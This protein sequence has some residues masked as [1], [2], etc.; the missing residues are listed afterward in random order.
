VST[1]KQLQ[2]PKEECKGKAVMGREIEVLFVGSTSVSCIERD[3]QLL[4]KYF[5]IKVVE[6]DI[7]KKTS[8]YNNLVANLGAGNSTE[9][10][11]KVIRSNEF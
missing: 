2:D 3:L 8:P 11:L 1:P 7:S 10:G 6:S 4:R 9:R 5:N